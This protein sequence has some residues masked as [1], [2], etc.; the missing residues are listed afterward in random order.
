MIDNL[1]IAQQEKSIGNAEMA[2]WVWQGIIES[3]DWN[4][5]PDQVD[6][7]VVALVKVSFSVG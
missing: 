4:S 5:R 3:F 6:A 7:G 1:K 2:E